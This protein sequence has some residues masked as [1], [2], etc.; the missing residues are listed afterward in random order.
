MLVRSLIV[1]GGII[2]LSSSHLSRFHYLILL[3]TCM[4][5]VHICALLVLL[6]ALWSLVSGLWVIMHTCYLFLSL[7]SS[8][9]SL[10]SQMSMS[11]SGD[12]TATESVMAAMDAVEPAV[13]K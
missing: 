11:M 9:L 8:S 4:S 5:N 13:K 2:T 6:S 3:Q 1:G 10:L 12:E 7:L